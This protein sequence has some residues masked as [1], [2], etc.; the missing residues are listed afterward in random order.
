MTLVVGSVEKDPAQESK[1]WPRASNC[2]DDRLLLTGNDHLRKKA[3]KQPLCFHW[4][5]NG[6]P[7]LLTN[8]DR[9]PPFP[10]ELQNGRIF[11][12]N[13]VGRPHLLTIIAYLSSAVNKN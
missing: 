2:R 1:G 11:T 10:L 7:T 6:G 12:T 3:R 4:S 5:V 8:P 9:T 13:L